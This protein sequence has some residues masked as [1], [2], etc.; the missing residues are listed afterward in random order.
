MLLLLNTA[1]VRNNIR[2]E[3]T[4]ASKKQQL[5]CTEH[6]QLHKSIKSVCEHAVC[7]ACL[8]KSAAQQQGM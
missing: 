7:E 3:A 2:V 6:A 5:C 4:D 8:Q 1:A